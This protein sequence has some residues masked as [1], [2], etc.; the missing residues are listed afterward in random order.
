MRE[1][2]N[3][4]NKIYYNTIYFYSVSYNP[5]CIKFIKIHY[6]RPKYICSSNESKNDD[7]S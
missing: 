5:L 3:L 2:Y 7:V 1:L 4:E 6:V